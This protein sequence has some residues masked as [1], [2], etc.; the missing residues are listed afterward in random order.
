VAATIY[1]KTWNGAEAPRRILVIRLQAL[2]DTVITLP[3]IQGL[4]TQFPHVSIDLLTR[5]EVSS[6]PARLGMFDRVIALRGGRSAKAQFIFALSNMPLLW[7]RRYDAVIDLQNNRISG[8]VRKLL[9]PTSWSEFDKYSPIPAGERT[10]LTIEAIWNWKIHPSFSFAN[11]NDSR[12]DELLEQH[13]HRPGYELVVLNPAGYCPSR[14]WPLSNYIAFAN[15]WR[16]AIN[17]LTQFVLLLLPVHRKKAKEIAKG[18]GDMCIDLTGKANQVEA[19]EIVAK[20]SLVLSEDSGLMHMAWVQRV[21][22]IALFSSSR[23][24]WSSP[25]G[26]WSYCLDSSDMECGPCNLEVCKYGDNR[27]LTRYSP[28]LVLGHAQRLRGTG[29]GV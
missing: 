11:N 4:K 2:G 22:T 23:K 20:A 29:V 25:Q 10:K 24:D 7:A 6:I 17:P 5:S 16:E 28:K 8:I 1:A 21:P 18:I 27:C 26:E 9:L 13:G 19:F 15:L 3:Y 12:A 14:N